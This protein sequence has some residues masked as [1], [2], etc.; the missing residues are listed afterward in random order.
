MILWQAFG[1]WR[2]HVG[3]DARIDAHCVL[4]GL[5]AGAVAVAATTNHFTL[6]V[7][8][9]SV[10]A[11]TTALGSVSIRIAFGIRA[12]RILDEARIYAIAIDAGSARVAFAVDAA[13]NRSTHYV[14]ISLVARLAR[15]C[16]AMILHEARG[17]RTAIARTAT[18]SIDARF[19]RR[20]FAVF[21]AS[22]RRF[23]H[24]ATAFAILVGH[25]QF[26][27]F[28]HHRSNRRAVQHT[29]ASCGGAR[30]QLLARFH[31]LLANARQ[32]ARTVVVVLTL[33]P[34]VQLH[35]FAIR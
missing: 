11:H 4:A 8:I 28:A 26:G 31:A 30:C 15:A 9:S 29:A 23:D 13:S 33:G 5:I 24:N 20:T 19:M 32:S 27:T 2:A 21:S 22:W 16:G 3:V 34:N 35:T 1:A 14:R 18:L 12:A 10:A 17:V 6:V 7:R 25:K